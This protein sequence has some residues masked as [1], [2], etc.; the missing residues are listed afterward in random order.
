LTGFALQEPLVAAWMVSGSGLEEYNPLNEFVHRAAEL[1]LLDKFGQVPYWLHSGIAWAAELAV[2]GTV[3]CFPYRDEFIG[4]GEHGGWKPQLASLLKAKDSAPSWKS[5]AA[6]QRGSYRDTAAAMAWG[7]AE[8]LMAQS[9]V[10]PSQVLLELDRIWRQDG[11]TVERFSDG[12]HRWRTVQGYEV[13]L[14]RQQAVFEQHLGVN[15][16]PRFA[17]HWR[18]KGK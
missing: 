7:M 9:G 13:P 12:G 15:L 2:C 11:I 18:E 4:V 16:L 1:R 8:F 17:A 14:E 3:Y 6:L 5:V 10:G